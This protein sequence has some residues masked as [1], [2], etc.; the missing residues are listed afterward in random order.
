MAAL[1]AR[2]HP[3]LRRLAASITREAN[4]EEGRKHWD[5]LVEAER[6][7]R[8][9]SAAQLTFCKSGKDRTAMAIT[10]QEARLLGEPGA[11]TWGPG[12]RAG[13]RAATL[14]RANVL[15]ANGVRLDISEKNVGRRKYSFNALQ[16][17]FMPDVYRPPT[18]CIDNMVTSTIKRDTS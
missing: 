16:L 6:A 1:V 13:S 17:R 9:L 10:L 11:P 15:R 3:L 5:I 14:R 12:K 2:F 18:E 7:A 4:D 8:A